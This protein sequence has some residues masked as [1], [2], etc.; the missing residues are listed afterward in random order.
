MGN[1]KFK[2]LIAMLALVFIASIGYVVYIVMNLEEKD[3]ILSKKEQEKLLELIESGDP[4]SYRD[5]LDYGG[6]LNFVYE[7]GDTPLEKLIYRN[8]FEGAKRILKTGFDLNRI[9]GIN[10]ISTISKVL[11]YNRLRYVEEIDAIALHL[12]NQVKDDVWQTDENGY[13]LLFHAIRTNNTRV[14]K[15]ILKYT[16]DL[17]RVVGGHTAL[18]YAAYYGAEPALIYTLLEHGAPVNARIDID[19]LALKQVTPAMVY[20]IFQGQDR[21][22]LSAFISHDDFDPNLSDEQGYTI[23]HHAVERERLEMVQ[24]ILRFTDIDP[25][26]KTKNGETAYDLAIRLAAERGESSLFDE[27]ADAI[28]SFANES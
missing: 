2:V 11:D 22:G 8:D 17:E 25:L 12:V 15:E 20:I 19:S 4:S 28:A 1:T 9:Q 3:E 6:K 26:I 13:P 14:V 16:S 24:M 7:D 27:I 21:S 5:Y 23:L 18:S 10:P